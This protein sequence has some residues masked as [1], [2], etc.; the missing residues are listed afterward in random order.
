MNISSFESIFSLAFGVQNQVL[1]KTAIT[2]TSLMTNFASEMRERRV[3]NPTCS[4]RKS[5][6][7]NK[8][9]L[10]LSYLTRNKQFVS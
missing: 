5:I 4:S 8:H 3:Q 10:D 9:S 2:R 7:R 1:C 6:C